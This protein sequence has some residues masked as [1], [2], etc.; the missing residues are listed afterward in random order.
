ME[1]LYFFES[2]RNPILDAF[3]SAVTYFGHELLFIILVLIMFWCVDKRGGYYL[4]VVGLGGTMINQGLKM[5]FRIPRP[6]VLDPDFTIVESAREAAT[7][8]SFPSG[9]TQCAVGAWGCVALW[10]KK[11]MVRILA[12][13]P[14]LLVP[15]S[16]MYLGVHTPLDVGVSFVIALLL[17]FAVYPLM[18]RTE[19]RPALLTAALWVVFALGAADILYLTLYN[20]PAD[21]DA[22]HLLDAVSTAWKLTGAALGMVL[23]WIIDHRYLHFETKAVWYAQIL[24]VVLGVAAVLLVK[25][26]FKAP[27]RAILPDSLADGV[28]YFL[29][30]VTAGS[31]WPLTFPYFAKLSQKNAK[32]ES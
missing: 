14:L 5:M 27:L 25:E 30:A 3:F 6:W 4:L 20:F 32:N 17:V 18:M 11:R 31:I 21:V 16:R 24:K 22:A 26:L 10:E 12:L 9:H 7:G 1:I 2:I 19:T 15:V 13:L 29:V 8:Y 23:V 28:R